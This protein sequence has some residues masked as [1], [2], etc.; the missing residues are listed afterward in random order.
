MTLREP[1][2]A[3]NPVNT[4]SSTSVSMDSQTGAHDTSHSCANQ[5]VVMHEP[6]DIRKEVMGEF[7]R[8][9]PAASTISGQGKAGLQLQAAGSRL[10]PPARQGQWPAQR[11][12]TALSACSD[13]KVRLTNHAMSYIRAVCDLFQ[14]TEPTGP[15]SNEAVSGTSGETRP[16]LIV[17]RSQLIEPVDCS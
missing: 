2:E 4:S 15:S 6:Q 11:I 13:A 16:P 10:P 9:R 7:T 12:E 8:L 3:L 1:Q 17:L 5:D 14:A